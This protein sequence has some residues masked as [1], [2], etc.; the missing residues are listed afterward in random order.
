MVHSLYET[1]LE[2]VNKNQQNFINFS[3]NFAKG[4][5]CEV[6]PSLFHSFFYILSASVEEVPETGVFL[7]KSTTHGHKKDPSP[8]E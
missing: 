7:P 5:L 4:G 3:L 1:L 6:G 2:S 8:N